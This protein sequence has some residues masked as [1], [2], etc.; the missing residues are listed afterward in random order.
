MGY[1]HNID[2][3]YLADSSKAYHIVEI[4][5]YWD[6]ENENVQKSNKQITIAV[7]EAVGTFTKINALITKINTALG[8]SLSALS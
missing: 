2:T 6:G 5:Y 7:E 3:A 1:P 4:G 8:T